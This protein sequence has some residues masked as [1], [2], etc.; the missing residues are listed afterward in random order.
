[1][2][3]RSLLL[4]GLFLLGSLGVPL[5]DGALYHL[6]GKDPCAGLTHVEAQG[7]AHH[8]DRCTLAQPSAPQQTAAGSGESVRISQ[9]VATA[10]GGAPTSAFPASPLH[11]I[12]HSRAPP[13]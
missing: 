7:S 3:S 11:S 4:L 6:A 2:R 13:A 10:V 9:P 5:T 12:R 8:A 1:M